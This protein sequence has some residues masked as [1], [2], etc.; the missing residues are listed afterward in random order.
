MGSVRYI[1]VKSCKIIEN[2]LI[3]DIGYMTPN[4][5]KPLCLVIGN[6]KGYIKK[7]NENKYLSLVPTDENEDILKK[8]GK[9]WNKSNIFLKQQII[10]QM[11]LMKNI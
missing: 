6:A 9:M 3:Y 4:S 7:S 10:T 8:Y 2:I 11:V 5:V 1:N